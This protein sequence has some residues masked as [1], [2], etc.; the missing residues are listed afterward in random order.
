MFDP[1]WNSNGL[2]EKAAEH[3]KAWFIK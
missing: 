2:L 1:E 3:I